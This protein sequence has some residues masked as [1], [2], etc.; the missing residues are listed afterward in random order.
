[1][2]YAYKPVIVKAKKV[3]LKA[4]KACKVKMRK[5]WLKEGVCSGCRYPDRVVTV[6]AKAEAK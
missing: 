2:K 5:L 4:C 1:M 6:V 3:K